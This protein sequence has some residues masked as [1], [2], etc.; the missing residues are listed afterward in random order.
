MA[1]PS[2]RGPLAPL[3]VR[4][5]SLFALTRAPLARN[6]KEKS[7]VRGTNGGSWN[8]CPFSIKPELFAPLGGE[9]RS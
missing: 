9:D 2:P 8:A 3:D 1:G 4:F 6:V 7:E 5:G